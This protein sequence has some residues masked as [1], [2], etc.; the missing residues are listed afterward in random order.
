[1]SEWLTERARNGGLDEVQLPTGSGRLWLCGKHLVGPDP[2]GALVRT[3]ASVVV[4]LTDIGELASRYPDYVDWL[5][6]NA[7]VR[8]HW[9]PIHD[10]HALSVAALGELVDTLRARVD[11]GEGVIVHCGAGIGRAGTVAAAILV[12]MGVGLGDALAQLAASRPSAG[13]QTAAQESALAE[14]AA[15][16]LRAREGG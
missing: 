6:A 3:G 12:S 1:M 10:M 5:R 4:C 8:A 13:P 9:V 16:A 15:V 14:F 7:G 11:A 2:E